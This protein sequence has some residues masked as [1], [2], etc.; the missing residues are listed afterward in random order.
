MIDPKK[1]IRQAKA[2]AIV[3]FM[4][5]AGLIIIS[6]GEPNERRPNPK[7]MKYAELQKRPSIKERIRA[8]QNK[9]EPNSSDLY[10]EGRDSKKG[11][12]STGSAFAID[13]KGHWMT[14]RHVV[15]DCKMIGLLKT[16]K[17]DKTK[18][19]A[20]V[21]NK[22]YNFVEARLLNINPSEDIAIITTKHV[23]QDYLDIAKEISY[24]HPNSQQGFALGFPDG[25]KGEAALKLIGRNNAVYQGYSKH[26]KQPVLV[27]LIS[28]RNPSNLYSLAGISGGPVINQDGEIVGVNTAENL[29]RGRFYSSSPQSVEAMLNKANLRPKR[30]PKHKLKFNEQNFIQNARQLDKDFRIARVLCFNRG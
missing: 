24:M 1:E 27:W 6:S 23:A 29:R 3:L 9:V 11:K 4:V 25:K 2:V 28:K 21:D 30:R 26:L 8:K 12:T 7:E 17:G 16:A 15:E 19:K 22:K 5:L 20:T 10:F 13:N 14:A 18:Y